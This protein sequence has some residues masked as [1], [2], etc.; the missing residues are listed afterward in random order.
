[1]LVPFPLDIVISLAMTEFSIIEDNTYFEVCINIT[2]GCLE[3]FAEAQLTS[4]DDSARGMTEYTCN[5]L[6]QVQWKHK[7]TLR[8]HL[9]CM[10][11]HM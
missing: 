1:M 10:L 3:R 6:G 9:S 7:F 4:M 5:Q 11:C 2:D 8:M